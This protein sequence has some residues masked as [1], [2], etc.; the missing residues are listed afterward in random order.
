MSRPPSAS[1]PT[2]GSQNQDD[3]PAKH[4]ALPAPAVP[5]G[6]IIGYGPRV[7]P[8][9]WTVKEKVQDGFPPVPD[10]A[11]PLALGER[12]WVIVGSSQIGRGHRQDGKY[13]EDAIAAA[14][15][16]GVWH[17]AAVADGGGSYTLARLGAQVAAQTAVVAMRA[18]LGAV[19]GEPGTGTGTDS[20][21]EEKARRVVAQ[22]LRAAHQ[23]LFAE[24]RR[25]QHEQE[26][27]RSGIA[28]PV[29]VRD[30][31]TTLL[32]ALHR[33]LRDGRHLVAGGQVGDGAVVARALEG[34]TRTLVW[35]SAPDT[36]PRGNETTFLPDVPDTE[37]EW[38][39]R[40]SAQAIGG[41]IV[42]CLAMTDGVADD[43]T[44]LD[45]HLWRLEKP[46]FQ[47]PLAEKTPE[48]AQ[49]NLEALLDYERQGSFD[50]RSLVCIY[51]QGTRPWT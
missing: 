25:L 39:Q 3:Q 7:V 14:I 18:A 33:R 34:D 36:G 24:A 51:Q 20:S 27:K 31:R 21:G 45:D 43:F 19:A 35:L 48:Q 37:A 29:T 15:V 12:G 49:R 44:P 1:T 46:L 28:V 32:L 30:L 10:V 26:E 17:L 38:Q 42:Y 8:A 41:T 9:G 23:A 40:V 47:G 22:G 5:G 16:D 4:A 13:R 11:P 2:P 50:D 6:T